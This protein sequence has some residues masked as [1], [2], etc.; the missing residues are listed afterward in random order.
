MGGL[1]LHEKKREKFV[2]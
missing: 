2:S 1:P